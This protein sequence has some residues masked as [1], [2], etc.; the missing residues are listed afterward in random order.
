MT[1]GAFVDQKPRFAS[2]ISTFHLH[3]AVARV[4]RDQVR[5]GRRQVDEVL[6]DRRAAMADVKAVV[7]RIRVAP[8]LP[9]RAR[10]DRPEVV[11]R[12]EVDARR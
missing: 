4:E 3:L 7:G 2:A 10:V 9:R 8:D 12:R 5:V 11:G 1:S 6:V